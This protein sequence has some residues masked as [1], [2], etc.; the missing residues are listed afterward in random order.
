MTSLTWAPSSTWAPDHPDGEVVPPSTDGFDGDP[1]DWQRQAT[2][3]FARA[4]Q[5][6]MTRMVMEPV[7]T[8]EGKLDLL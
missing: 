1:L 2:S 8:Q 4:M 5:N 7:G 6:G 3:I